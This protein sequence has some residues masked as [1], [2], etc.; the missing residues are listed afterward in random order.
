V[1]RIAQLHLDVI[2]LAC[3]PDIRL[4]EFAKKEQG[5]SSLLTQGEPECVLLAALF[6]RLLYVPG[7]PVEPIGRTGSGNALMR[8]LMIVIADPM[9]QPLTG[10]GKGGK[11]RIG[12]ELLP[13]RP[14]E[15]LDLS[16]RHRVMGRTAY[17]LHPL[18]A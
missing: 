4:P 18:P 8:P 2:S 5:M 13:D 14:P 7:D 3:D 16:Q 17:V 15:S 1:D 11:Q 9:G 6:E 12:Q 10:I